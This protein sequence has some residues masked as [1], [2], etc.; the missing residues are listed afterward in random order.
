M[1]THVF[2]CSFCRTITHLSDMFLCFMC[3][4]PVCEACV[5]YV[6]RWYHSKICCGYCR[7]SSELHH[8]LHYVCSQTCEVTY[9][10][11]YK[12]SLQDNSHHNDY[13]AG[14]VCSI[15]K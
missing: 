1:D 9:M 4:V 12:M 8:A 5:T 7:D 10:M 13:I 15:P 14:G 6:G 11:R 3:S 2:E